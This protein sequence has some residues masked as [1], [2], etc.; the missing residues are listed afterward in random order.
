MW[1][2]EITWKQLYEDI[3]VKFTKNE[4]DQKT[5]IKEI[6]P[7]GLY[8]KMFV[9][10]GKVQG[11]YVSLVCRATI[12]A[13]KRFLDASDYLI[14]LKNEAHEDYNF[15]ENPILQE[16][17]E[18]W[19][20]L[21]PACAET[22]E[23]KVAK[24]VYRLIDKI[25]EEKDELFIKERLFQLYDKQEYAQ[26]LAV[27][28]II[29][30]TLCSFGMENTKF[31]EQDLK[32]HSL[33]LPKLVEEEEESD[34]IKIAQ[35][36]LH[37]EEGSLEE[38]KECLGIALN[39][40][41]EKGKA[42]YLLARRA[43]QLKDKKA[44][45]AFLKEAVKFSYEPAKLWKNNADAEAMLEK[46][47]IIYQNPASDGEDVMRCC[48]GCEKILYLTPAVEKSYRGEAAF[49]L[50]KYIRAGKYQSS[51]NETADYYL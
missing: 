40:P 39:N 12:D 32:L 49:V 9:R 2:I 27:F 22:Q 28:S 47:R 45:N 29:A 24:A 48:K 41:Y 15:E 35:E 4:S 38:L 44:G 33:F 19:K 16:F 17:A 26:I 7:D 31:S 36:M 14:Q 37:R 23:N 51:T 18:N 50:Y 34:A 43:Y 30:S 21:V 1:K 25:E 11:K 46:I 8:Q 20:R 42:N 13:K 6:F 3:Y 10:G 5:F